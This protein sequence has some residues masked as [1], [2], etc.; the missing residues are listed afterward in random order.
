MSR[1]RLQIALSPPFLG[2]DAGVGSTRASWRP[3]LA[4]ATTAARRRGNGVVVNGS[5]DPL[6]VRDP[7]LGVVY[8][9]DSQCEEHAA[10]LLFNYAN[11]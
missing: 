3:T 4:R 7:A 5:E 1:R 10:G 8:A 11:P 6:G 9:Q 2:R